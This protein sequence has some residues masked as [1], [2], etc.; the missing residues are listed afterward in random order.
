[1]SVS[2]PVISTCGFM[3]THTR[4]GDHNRTPALGT[5]VENCASPQVYVFVNELCVVGQV[6]TKWCLPLVRTSPRP[7]AVSP[8]RIYLA[9]ES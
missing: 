3:S 2:T 9:H 1:M 5:A 7:A 6:Y 8:G 4:P